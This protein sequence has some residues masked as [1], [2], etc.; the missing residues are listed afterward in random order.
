MDTNIKYI[1]ENF[2]E[3]DEICRT[4]GIS[5]QELEELIKKELVPNASYKIDATFKI[6]SPLGDEKVISETKKYFQK[7]IINLI[8][9]NKQKHSVD[10]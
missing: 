2:I 10:L 5:H 1:E 3:S 6:N 9:S 7:D 8:N 4:T